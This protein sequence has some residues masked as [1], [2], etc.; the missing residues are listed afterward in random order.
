MESINPKLT[1]YTQIYLDENVGVLEDSYLGIQ[2]SRKQPL[3][4]YQPSKIMKSEKR[5]VGELIE[6]RFL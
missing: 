5:V 6:Y 3:Q 4:F 2:G 1:K